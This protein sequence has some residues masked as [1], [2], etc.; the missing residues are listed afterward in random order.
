MPEIDAILVNWNGRDQTPVAIDSLLSLS[1]VR[2]NPDLLRI[3][4]SDNGSS[5][6]SVALL[7]ERYGGRI[8]IIEN[9]SNLG[10][11]AGA[12]R[13]IAATRA[14]FVFLLN[15]DATVR[16]CSLSALLAFMRAHPKCAIAGPKIFESD[17]RIAESCGEFDSWT[18]AFLR[19]SGW[20]DLP[21]LRRFANGAALREW[22][23]NSE[24][25]VD[26]VIGAAMMIRRDVL[27]KI[28]AFDERYFMYHE[29]VDLARRAHDA[30]YESWFVPQAQA[31]H[32][33]MGSSGG[34]NVEQWKTR[35][36]RLYWV[37]HHG[38]AWYY[39]L[40]AALVLR[41]ALYLGVLAAIAFGIRRLLVR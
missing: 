9:G 12:N 16:D 5:D 31:T 25:K 20:G 4:V 10:F 18:G 36:R 34:K 30:G 38:R 6:G 33:G 7:R 2:A 26:L 14:P 8:D 17:G 15:P 19:S 28:G 39:T 11:G 24:R 23:Y 37:K 13:A 29:E 35:S 27:E 40:S 1:E 22:D 32:A 41:Y 3:T 21:P